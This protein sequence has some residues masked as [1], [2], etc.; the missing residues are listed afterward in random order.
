MSHHTE[1][2]TK[3]ITV[4][5]IRAAKGRDEAFLALTAYTMPIARLVNRHADLVL[6]GDSV[7]MV[8]Y[9][10]KDTLSVTLEMMIV[11]G[12][13]VAAEC[14][15]S[16]CVIDMPF[17]SYQ[18]SPSQAFENAARV[19]QATGADAIK[20]EGGEE[21]AETIRFLTQR[22]VPVLAHVGLRPQS[23]QVMGGYKVQGKSPEQAALLKADAKAVAEAGAFAVV[24]EGTIENVAREISA[25]IGI[26]TI[27]I[28]ASG[29]CDGQILVTDD[30][31]GL[32]PG[33]YAKFVT[34][35][36]QLYETAGDA[37]ERFA[38]DVKTR[39]FPSAQNVYTG[40]A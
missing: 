15:H 3:K 24:I 6:V 14:T 27:G 21:M 32:T 29:A 8:V 36:A 37:I 2:S 13:A 11:H 23:V 16:L 35:Y 19:L 9:G 1:T 4:A 25:S 5:T 34:P 31:L 28:G 10:M 26:P 20:L 30:L 7:G 33:P 17:G 39:R 40:K 18:A 38:A 22:G 12:K